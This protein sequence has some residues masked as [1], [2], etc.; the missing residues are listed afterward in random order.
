VPSA[1]ATPNVAACGSPRCSSRWPRIP[2]NGFERQTGPARRGP[3]SRAHDGG[4]WDADDWR[5]WRTR[6]WQ[7][8]GRA[9]SAERQP[10]P[11]AAPPGTGPRDHRSSFIT[12]QVYTGVPVTTIAT[13]CG[14]SVTMIEKH[15]A[16]VIENWDGVQVPAVDQIRG[17][18]TKNGRTVDA[19]SA[20]AGS[21]AH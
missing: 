19:T 11:G 9:K 20:D 10:Y 21:P 14:T 16:G 7:G 8:K 13:Q 3:C 17:A 12:L 4:F 2:A 5:N 18:R 6:I 1:I 15:Y